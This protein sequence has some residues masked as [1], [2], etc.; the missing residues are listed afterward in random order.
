LIPGQTITDISWEGDGLRLCAAVDSHLFFANIRLDYKWAY[1][2][3]TV[4]Y[5]YE[6]MENKEHCV[7][8][9]Q[10]KLEEAY[11]QYVKP[12]VALASSNE[13]CILIT[14]VDNQIGQY[15]MQICNGIGTTIDSKYINLEPKY[16]VMNDSEVVIA[17]NLSFTIWKY[18]IPCVINREVNVNVDDSMSNDQKLYYVDENDEI[19][20]TSSNIMRGR[21][22]VIKLLY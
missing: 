18:N 3:H 5:S 17:N 8:F 6:R 20:V 13:H 10:T 19:D 1:C 7:V 12:I 4:I 21:V 2:G 9:F 14:R 15:L 11:L 16:V 22:Q